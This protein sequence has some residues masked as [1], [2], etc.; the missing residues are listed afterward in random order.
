MRSDDEA[1][2]KRRIAPEL[3]AGN[4][5]IWFRTIEEAM[6]AKGI[7]QVIGIDSLETLIEKLQIEKANDKAAADVKQKVK[8]MDAKA[9]QL[10]R[11]HLS[12]YDLELLDDYKTAR[13]WWQFLRKKYGRKTTAQNHQAM[14]AYVNFK[15]TPQMSVDEGWATLRSLAKDAEG[16][17]G[18]KHSVASRARRLI[19]AL[20]SEYDATKSV[21]RASDYGAD[22]ILEKIKEKEATLKTSNEEALAAR[23]SRGKA[24]QK[25]E[26]RRRGRAKPTKQP[27]NAKVS[28]FL[29]GE[30]SSFPRL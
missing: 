20:P 6:E 13:G 27:N 23:V 18:F 15:M 29:R 25:S 22:V 3:T 5:R 2:L 30:P 4:H 12:E 9:R 17:D 1:A 10:M 28:C 7:E 26:P 24:K 21:L 14:V 19:E 11:R 8:Q 16:V